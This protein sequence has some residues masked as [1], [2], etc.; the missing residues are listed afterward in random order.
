MLLV[1]MLLKE[2]QYVRNQHMKLQPKCMEVAHVVM[3]LI[4]RI[5][6]QQIVIVKAIRLLQHR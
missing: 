3:T 5:S 2:I 4:V 6:V 1:M